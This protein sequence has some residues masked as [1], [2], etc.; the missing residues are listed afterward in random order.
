MHKIT[1]FQLRQTVWILASF[2]ALLASIQV[3]AGWAKPTGPQTSIPLKPT[4]ALPIPD[5]QSFAPISA[6]SGWIL[7]NQH[8]YWTFDSGAT[9]IDRTPPNLG[10]AEIQTVRFSDLLTGWL[11]FTQ[12]AEI[13]GVQ[14]V[15]S[16]TSDG[17]LSWNSSIIAEMPPEDPDAAVAAAY[18]DVLDEQTLRVVLKRA[19]SP[20]FSVGTL[21]ST[22]DGGQSWVR[23]SMP[24][25]EPVRFVSP[26]VGWVAGGAAGNELFVTRDG[27]ETWAGIGVDF[28]NTEAH[29][30]HYYLPAFVDSN[31]GTLPVLQAQGTTSEVIFFVTNDS[32]LTWQPIQTVTIIGTS[33]ID[34]PIAH[35]DPDFWL[36]AVDT[37][38]FAQVVLGE[39]PST[40]QFP[41]P[42]GANKIRLA[43]RAVAWLQTTEGICNEGQ[44]PAEQFCE[45]TTQ[46]SSSHDSGQTWQT[47]VLPGANAAGAL[48]SSFSATQLIGGLS[49]EALGERTQAFVGQGFDSC[50]LPSAS[51]M[52]TWYNTSPYKVWNLYIGGASRANCGTLTASFI[53]SLAQQGWRFIPTWVGP[54]A[55]CS[56]FASRISNDPSTAYTQGVSEADAAINRAAELGLTS[57]D[58]TGT[59][60][61]YDLEAYTVGDSA[62]R[63]ATK[64]FISGWTGQLRTRGTV[65][66][67]YGS[68]CGSALSDFAGIANVPDGIWAAQWIQPYQYRS[69]ATVWGLSCVSDTLWNGSQ[70][71]RQYS[72]GHSETWGGITINID[73][74]VTNGI[75]AWLA[76]SHDTIDSAR[77]INNLPY[78][79]SANTSNATVAA[80]DPILSHCGLGQGLATVWYRFTA[81]RTGRIHLD[82]F[83]S[84]YDT[85]LAV[86]R[87]NPD[88]LTPVARCN[89]DFGGTVQSTMAVWLTAGTTYYI[90]VAHYSASGAALEI[91]NAKPDITSQAGGNLILHAR[92]TQPDGDLD[93]D[94]ISD[95]ALYY[96]T[97]TWSWVTSWSGFTSV[98]SSQTF[99]VGGGA[100]PLLGNDFDGDGRT[101][102]AMFYPDW[103]QLYWQYSSDGTQGQF[104]Y[105]TNTAHPVAIGAYDY[106]GDSKTD[107]ALFYPSNG[108]W[109]WKNS[110]NNSD[111]LVAFNASGGPMPIAKADLNGDGKS[112]P[113][114]FYTST[115]LFAW[116]VNGTV[117][118]A[119]FNP[120]GN[121]QPFL[122][123]FDGDG[124]SD[125]AVYYQTWA[126]WAWKRSSDGQ[127]NT[128]AFNPAGSPQPVLG[129][130]DNDNKADAGLYYAT[131][132]L[133]AWKRSTDGV[134][135]LAAYNPG[136][137]PEPQ[138]GGD[139]D[140]DGKSDPAL[141]YRAWG[142]WAWK[143]SSTGTDR[144]AA[145]NGG[146]NPITIGGLDFDGDGKADP[147][148][149]HRDWGLWVWKRSSD[150]TVITKNMNPA[151]VFAPIR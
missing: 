27:G 36:L 23:H 9:W 84:D 7:L 146:G 69:D 44:T 126:L 79:D 96:N 60:I 125:P 68:S 117:G 119:A 86:W 51:Q 151:N 93:G 128:A 111:G 106:D 131:W 46:L 150:G 24:I 22:T 118:T 50:T 145:Y 122:N 17:G 148:L 11:V 52:Q 16:K 89:D 85:M 77:Q 87:G 39:N 97:G 31:V 124:K 33:V 121:P 25:G 47:V 116:N 15:L 12:L 49:A 56:S 113:A 26:E 149:Y 112:D 137:N 65:A 91:A 94:G 130:F 66:A 5:L 123:D 72:G 88:S 13:G 133:W 28:G 100:M 6:E 95:P 58:K 71:L 75:T 40:I 32:G 43:N 67:V 82:T 110:S 14:V 57:S 30:R 48:T 147:A 10:M 62:C 45:T 144:T 2:S 141:Y 80:G 41:S 136:G 107:P 63:N 114:L 1:S 42:D 104:G 139:F 70:R 29:Q 37:D 4:Q 78:T 99:G 19:T 73:S 18:L 20:N 108:V 59:I 102:P 142:L 105:Y 134:I 35:A 3:N 81:S 140:G 55:P 61:Y 135:G 109:S 90:E 138:L 53:S 120:D 21:F 92:Y 103:G 34:L 143:E 64:S 8:L 54:Q 83:G 101:D 76:P 98:A 129:F 115:G 74:N 127:I 38:Q 132:G